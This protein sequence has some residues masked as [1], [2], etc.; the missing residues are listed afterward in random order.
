MM[1]PLQASRLRAS[2]WTLPEALK[3]DYTFRVY[4]LR[5]ESR[6]LQQLVPRLGVA[7]MPS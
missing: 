2:G 6:W 3:D 1:E 5:L 4:D 7:T